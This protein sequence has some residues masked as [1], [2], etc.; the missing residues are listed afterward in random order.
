MRSE[1][2][3]GREPNIDS[4]GLKRKALPKDP[5]LL[6]LSLPRAERRKKHMA[7]VV[8]FIAQ[9]KFFQAFQ[10]DRGI[11]EEIADSVEVRMLY[12]YIYMQGL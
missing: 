6:V 3:H 10:N 8:D 1:F 12:I 7:A 11:L 2:V 4:S 9:L 5:T